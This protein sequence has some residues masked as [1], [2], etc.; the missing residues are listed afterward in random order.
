RMTWPS[1]SSSILKPAAVG[2]VL[3]SPVGPAAG[4]QVDARNDATATSS[5]VAGGGAG[6]AGAVAGVPARAGVAPATG[7]L[8][9]EQAARAVAMAPARMIRGIRRV[10]GMGIDSFG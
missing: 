1:L 9:G 5:M 6:C 7:S 3:H 10:A 4:P 8:A 2:V